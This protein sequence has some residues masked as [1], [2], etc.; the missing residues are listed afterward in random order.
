[1]RLEAG[2]SMLHA[3]IKMGGTSA[4][5]MPTPITNTANHVCFIA[6]RL[7]DFSTGMRR[8]YGA[9]MAQS[10]P[11]VLVFADFPHALSGEWHQELMALVSRRRQPTIMLRVRQDDQHAFFIRRFV[12]LIHERMGVGIDGQY[13]VAVDP[14]ALG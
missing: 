8:G 13:C 12:E 10:S 1:M 6:C 3:S 7:F 4:A 11:E 9:F 14:L 2:S 5:A